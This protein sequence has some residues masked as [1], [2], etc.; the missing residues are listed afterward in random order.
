[1]GHHRAQQV[2]VLEDESLLRG[3]ICELLEHSIPGVRARPAATR[4]EAML[5]LR[6]SE[7]EQLVSEVQLAG[8]NI[9][10]WLSEAL[11]NHPVL[12]LTTFSTLFPRLPRQLV[13][14]SRFVHV[15]KTEG[16][17][18]RLVQACRVIL[19]Q[20]PGTCRS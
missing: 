11:M 4:D 19:E 16:G 15:P 10:G 1:V 20:G 6:D 8:V 14:S 13:D 18:R 9:S 5:L 17:L 2:L 3:M 7:I 12:G